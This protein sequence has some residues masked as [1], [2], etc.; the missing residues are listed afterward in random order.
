MTDE[1]LS[2]TPQQHLSALPE[3]FNIPTQLIEKW[4]GLPPSTYISARL[5][6][7]DIDH[8]FFSI[9]KSLQAQSLT[10]QCLI[11]WTNGRIND[12]NVSLHESKRLLIDSGNDLRQFFT[13]ILASVVSEPGHDG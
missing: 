8:L 6:R 7:R 10:Q 5:T 3:D 9:N 2:Q 12:A 11:D 1:P 4:I 13:G